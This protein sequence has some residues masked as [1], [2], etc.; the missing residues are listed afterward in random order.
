MLILGTSRAYRHFYTDQLEK[1]ANKSF[2]NLGL[3][4]SGFKSENELL[5]YY[6][7]YNNY[8]KEII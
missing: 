2:F 5:R 6:L 4:A 3:N 1:L 8:P 7:K